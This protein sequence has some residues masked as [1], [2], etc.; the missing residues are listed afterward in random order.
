MLK[1][2]VLGGSFDPI[3]LGHLSLAE[4]LRTETGLDRVLFMPTYDSY[5][6]PSHSLSHH[7]VRLRLIEKAIASNPYFELSTLEIERKKPTYTYETF[8]ELRALYPLDD[9]YFLGGSDLVFGLENWV[10]SAYLLEHASFILALR[11]GDDIELVENKLVYLKQKYRARIELVRTPLMD[12]SSSD[13]RDRIKK[14]KSI[15]YMM[16]EACEEMVRDLGLYLD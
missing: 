11:A 1:I 15:R 16:T 12:L 4:G 2:G 10:H 13:I 5:H 3:H 14:N 9:I 6:K 8:D 7:D